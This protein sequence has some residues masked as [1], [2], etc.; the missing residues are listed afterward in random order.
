MSFPNGYEGVKKLF[1]SEILNLIG[2]FCLLISGCFSVAMLAEMS[3]GAEA[4]T[5]VVG[6]GTIVFLVASGVVSLIAYIFKL[7]GLKKAGDDEPN[8]RTAF[9]LAIFGLVVTL[10]ATIIGAINSESGVAMNASRVF[11]SVINIAITVLVIA[12]VANVAH[13][14]NK[15]KIINAGSKLLTIIVVMYTISIIAAL[16]PIFF[17]TGET[18]S[19]ISGIL[20]IVSAVF[21]IIAY[22]V[23]LVYLGKAKK[24]LR[25][26]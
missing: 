23:F 25:D 13:A 18:T 2:G 3:E 7:I 8:F 4:G 22:I 20:A 19:T 1:T 11:G 16:I 10:A 5:G 12:G 24:M 14:L 15:P 17:G 26:N 9:I 21:S 6:I